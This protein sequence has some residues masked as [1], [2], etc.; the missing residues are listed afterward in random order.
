ME[1]KKIKKLQMVLK[2]NSRNLYR[3]LVGSL[4]K[5]GNRNTARLIVKFAFLRVSQILQKSVSFLFK[6]LFY[7]LRVFS[8]ARTI[9]K[10]R[11]VHIVPFL[12]R[13]NRR[14]F[15]VSKWLLK[16]VL[17]NRQRIPV[18]FKLI[19]ELLAIFKKKGSEALKEKKKNTKLVLANRANLH[20][21]W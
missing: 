9:S 19:A 2:H 11:R 7:R 4:T 12:I 8:E 21:R 15:L 16:G 1:Q 14:F 6:A 3:K 13:T 10:R 17:N 20:F 5:K 18:S